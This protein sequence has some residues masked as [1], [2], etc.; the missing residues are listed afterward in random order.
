MNNAAASTERDRGLLEPTLQGSARLVLHHPR[1]EHL[2]PEGK[3]VTRSN[4]AAD[5]FDVASERLR[6][7]IQGIG[8]DK[9]TRHHVWAFPHIKRVRKADSVQQIILRTQEYRLDALTG[10]LHM[11]KGQD[12][13]GLI[14]FRN[15]TSEFESSA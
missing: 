12:Q 11:P 5:K 3:I 10:Y 2:R 15:F 14:V 8:D 9:S 4:R 13:A 1:R 7:Q 6:G